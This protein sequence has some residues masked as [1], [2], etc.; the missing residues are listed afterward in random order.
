MSKLKIMVLGAGSIGARHIKNLQGLGYKNITIADTS[1]DLLKSFSGKFSCYEDYAVALKKER[2]DVVFICTPTKKHIAH[3]SLALEYGCHVFIEKP[4]SDNLKSVSKLEKIINGKTVMVACNWRFNKAF[5]AMEKIIKSAKFGKVLYVRIAACYFLPNARPNFDF[6][7]VYAS[8]QKGGGVLLDTGSHVINY[9]DALFGELK[10][11]FYLMNSLNYL[12]INSEEIVHMILQYRNGVTC[13]IT[14]DY[15]SKKTINRIEVVCEKGL[16]TLNLVQNRITVENDSK[17]EVL[18]DQPLDSN[19]MFTDE[20]KHFFNC[21]DEGK[22]PLQ[23]L[24]DAKRVLQTLLIKCKD[25][26]NL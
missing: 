24:E 10:N 21:I 7:N 4:V 8:K 26:N 16:I 19:Q 25:V 5:L 23:D 14:F 2:P 9:L 20:L 15:V 12:N 22:K 18:F 6:K 17:K 13:D 11:G 3:A 1:K